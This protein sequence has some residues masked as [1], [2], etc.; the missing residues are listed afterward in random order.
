MKTEELKPESLRDTIINKHYKSR[1]NVPMFNE[2]PTTCQG[3]HCE[4][5]VVMKREMGRTYCICQNC[6]IYFWTERYVAA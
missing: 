6:G 5:V 2:E 3:C 4:Y 1:P